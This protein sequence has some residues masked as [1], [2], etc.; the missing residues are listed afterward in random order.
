MDHG[1]VFTPQWTAEA[2]I[3]L[4]SDEA[5]RIDSRFL[6]PACGEGI[7]L[8]NV[9]KKKLATV[10]RKYSG[11]EFE[12]RHY[13]LLALMSIYGIE[14]LPDNAEACRLRLVEDFNR[15]LRDTEPGVWSLAAQTVVQANIVQADALTMKCADGSP[16]TFA[17]WAYVGKGLYQRRDFQ[18]S[19]LTQRSS[20]AG[21]LFEEMGTEDIFV[22][23]R[24]YPLMNVDD[25]AKEYAD[26]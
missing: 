6:E 23:H 2:M 10:Q 11:R 14:L 8:T 19:N 13:S 26:K 5:E 16:L 18:Y 7:F 25:L 12:R 22:P 3:N 24:T 17:E 4:V 21:T 20:F 15:S 9:L 1:E